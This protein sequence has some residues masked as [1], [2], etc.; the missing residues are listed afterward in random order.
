MAERAERASK[1]LS[2]GKFYTAVCVLKNSE[3][4]HALL[5]LSFMQPFINKILCSSKDCFT[6]ENSSRIEKKG[7]KKANRDFVQVSFIL[8]LPRREEK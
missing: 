3:W 1:N 7:K 5:S 6:T 2:R 4:G 8:L